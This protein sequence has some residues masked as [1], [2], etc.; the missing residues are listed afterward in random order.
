MNEGP[1]ARKQWT[2]SK[3]Q[4]IHQQAHEAGHKAAMAH[5]PRPMV[6]RDEMSGHT[7]EPILDGVCGFAWVVIR[8]G[9]SPYANFL[10]RHNLGDRGYGG[11]V[12]IWVS[13]Y[14]QSMEKKEAYAQAYAATVCA[15]GI[16]AS[17]SSR[18]D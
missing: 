16:Q 12:H 11:G 1:K 10:K 13:D 15:N 8:P 7:Y 17:W 5:N 2:E 6:I 4:A 9:N 14:N 18:M 3:L